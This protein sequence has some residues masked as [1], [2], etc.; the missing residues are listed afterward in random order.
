M[1]R[2]SLGSVAILC[3]FSSL[4]VPGAALGKNRST[5]DYCW[6]EGEQPSRTNVTPTL[7]GWGNAEFLADGK[8]L[9]LSI[10]A[11]EIEKSV[12]SAGVL[13]AYNAEISRPGRFQVW[14]RIGFEF[15][16]SPFDWRVDDGPWSSVTPDQLTTDLME[17]AEWCE[18]A[19]LKL[20][21]V[22]LN[23]GSHVVEFRLRRTLGKNKQP[24]RILFALD[25]LCLCRGVFTPHGRFQPDDDGRDDRDRQAT[26]VVFDL[27]EPVTEAARVALPLAGLWEVCRYDEQYPGE[28][29]TPIQGVPDHPNWHA[30]DVP[31][32]KNTVRPD[33]KFAHRLWYRT[34][35]RVPDSAAGRSFH[36]VFPENNLNTTVVV[37]GVQCGF[38]K[39][40]F[41]R[42]EIDVTQGVQ[43]G[44]NELWV[45]IRDA[46]YG[47]ST[48]PKDPLKLRKKFNLPIKFFGQG[49]QD[50]A[51][52]IWRHPQ[53]G[54]LVAPVL[55]PFTRERVSF[56]VVRNPLTAG[57]T[58]GDIVMR[59]GERIFGWTRD[60]YVAADTY[61]YVVDFD[62]VAPFA[63]FPD[64]FAR[65]MVNGM[66]TAD[67]WKYIVN[68]PA[69]DKPPL[70]WEL[71]FPKAQ[72]LVE[73][74]WTGNT[75]YY[76]VTNVQLFFD[77]D[78]AHAA[79]FQ[80]EPTNDPQVF[81]IKPSIHGTRLTLRLADWETPHDKR[82][83][84]GLDNIALKA[85]RTA[86]FYR[87]V[88]PL[89][90]IGAMLQYVDGPGGIILC[91][92]RFQEHEA[93][94]ENGLKKQRILSA[95]LRNLKAPFAQGKTIVAGAKMRYV[96]LD[97]AGSCNQ[98]RDERGWFGDKSYTFSGLPAG[99]QTLAGVPFEI[100]DFPTSPVP[101]VIMLGGRRVPNKLP[102]E[103]RG[104]PLQGK[105]DALF[106]LHTA[107]IDRRRNARELKEAKEVD[108]CHYVVTY[109]DG[110]TCDIPI[111]GEIDVENYRQEKPRVI[112][113]A[114]LAWMRPYK[115]T[116]FSAVAYVKQWNNPRPDT[117]LK[118]L[119]IV[120]GQQRRG[121][122]C[123]IAVTAAR[124]D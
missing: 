11:K 23:H 90:N 115:G 8:W 80:T 123:L 68:V 86:E 49:F 25:A 65:N 10:A 12:P 83:V 51:Y 47:Y 104:I 103:V 60:E 14:A 112:P 85:R 38:N 63:A 64:D 114:Q 4:L 101:T 13:L 97:I 29:A 110:Q 73:L 1:T 105:A 31:G 94:P 88:R 57:L 92:L 78:T 77:G 50:L 98:Y 22:D 122:P 32:D 15:V 52:P 87:R 66:M 81:P 33:L 106:F 6:I 37:N 74:T 9:S 20:G 118:S 41:A 96:P 71:T 34:R 62:D 43:P 3:V 124:V 19:W 18:V 35:F 111:R 109:A 2:R 17:I 28:T 5:A 102:D 44:V 42:F 58:L 7:N 75:I 108:L 100:Y 48:D 21:E 40:P 121:V 55:V 70:D 61:S 113:G 53:S 45:G 39:N 26:D 36:V 24:R 116:G 93:V 117:E 82:P 79:T 95:I 30:I 107:R 69:P 27:P 99:R 56:P 16:R 54:I 120:Y 59:S 119:D 91:N 84:T 46:W 89:L 76:P 72:E 67:A